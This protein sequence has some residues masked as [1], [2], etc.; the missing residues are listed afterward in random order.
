MR[1]AVQRK[2]CLGVATLHGPDSMWACPLRSRCLIYASPW[3]YHHVVERLRFKFLIQTN[4]ACTLLVILFLCRFLSFRPFQLYFIPLILLTT[5]RF[6]TLFFRLI[7][8]LLVLSIIYFFM[9][10]FCSP[11]VV[12]CGWLGL[13][14]QLTK[15]NICYM[16][17]LFYFVVYIIICYL[18]V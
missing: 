2:T 5:F 3:A 6:L 7:S 9:K 17:M 10:V 12:F 16:S 4:R 18:S 1:W 15:S 13:K 11:N 14:H 8:A